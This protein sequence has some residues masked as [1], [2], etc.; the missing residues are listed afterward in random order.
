MVSLL[1]KIALL[2]LVD[3]RESTSHIN[4]FAIGSIPVE[5]SSKMIRGG[6]PI[7]AMATDNLHLLP[8]LREWEGLFACGHKSNSANFPSTT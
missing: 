4:R 5:C 7:I 1:N 2:C 3:I 6:S 8:L